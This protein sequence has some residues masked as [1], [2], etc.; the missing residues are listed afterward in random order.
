[1]P[2]IHKKEDEGQEQV[3]LVFDRERPR[4]RK[5]GAAVEADV[6]HGNEKFP[7]WCHFRVF[8]PRWQQYVNGEDDEVGWQNAQGATRE[9]AAKVDRLIARERRKQLAA[10]QVSAEDKE[11]IDTDPAEAVDA[12]GKRKAHDAGVINDHD[13]DGERA[14][15]IET[16]LALAILKA[17]INSEPEWR[18]RFT[19]KIPAPSPQS[20]LEQGRG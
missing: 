19:H 3:K 9:E 17:W 8:A 15:K 5:R 16:R 4:V 10:D 7:P 18:F 12:A 2:A 11:K 1:M 6:L 13:D 20:S 14:K